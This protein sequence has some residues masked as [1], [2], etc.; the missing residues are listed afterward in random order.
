M[1][2]AAI[3]LAHNI[4]FGKVL[5]RK[6]LAIG[7][8]QEQFA[9]KSGFDRTYIGM[10]ERGV[11]SPSLTTLLAFCKILNMD[12]RILIDEFMDEFNSH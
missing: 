11:N 8:T 1:K 5:R 7:L 12:L 2:K 10:V 6:R 4:A 3:K 9:Q